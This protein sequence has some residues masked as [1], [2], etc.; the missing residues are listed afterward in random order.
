[1][2]GTLVS[3]KE[4]EEVGEQGLE[5]PIRTLRGIVGWSERGGVTLEYGLVLG[6]RLGGE[7]GARPR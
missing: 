5:L 6:Y 3:R 1:M 4:V 7:N 2:R